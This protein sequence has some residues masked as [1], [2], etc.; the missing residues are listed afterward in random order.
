MQFALASL[1]LLIKRKTKK[2]YTN[3][4]AEGCI[5]VGSL[6]V[7]AEEAASLKPL[8]INQLV[9]YEEQEAY[10]LSRPGSIIAAGLA[11]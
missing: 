5:F 10:Y 8:K 6:S 7:N 9:C 2:I 11:V 1:R 3:L 4:K